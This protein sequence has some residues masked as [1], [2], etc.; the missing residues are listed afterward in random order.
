VLEPAIANAL[1][2]PEAP[3]RTGPLLQEIRR[4][5]WAVAPAQPRNTS[6]RTRGVPSAARGQGSAEGMADRGGNGWQPWWVSC[7]IR[8]GDA[9]VT[10]LRRF[11]CCRRPRYKAKPMDS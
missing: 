2:D 11:R 3:C 5:V 1:R 9:S 7:C 8:L 10:A 6:V 4:Y